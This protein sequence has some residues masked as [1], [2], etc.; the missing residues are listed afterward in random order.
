MPSM[1]RNITTAKFRESFASKDEPHRP[2][3]ELEITV[4]TNDP[5]ALLAALS[6]ICAAEAGRTADPAEAETQTAG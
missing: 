2:A 4:R 3:Y 6:S 1:H 5:V